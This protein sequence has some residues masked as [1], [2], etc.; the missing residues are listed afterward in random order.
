[1]SFAE[2]MKAAS[3]ELMLEVE[4][5]VEAVALDLQG[6]IIARSPVDKGG[7]KQS[8]VI[9][10]A[11]DK[12]GYI[13]STDKPYAHVL[14]YG[15]YPKDV[16]YGSRTAASGGVKHSKKNPSTVW[17]QKTNDGFSLQAPQ[18]FVRTSILDI[19][20]KYGR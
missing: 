4:D 5:R 13:I 10:S 8:W 7:L 20:N 11:I 3:R 12:S 6:E 18:G 16:K 17:V 19:K 15:L 14:E 9:A 2:R 1:M